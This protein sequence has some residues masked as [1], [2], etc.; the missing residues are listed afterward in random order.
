MCSCLLRYIGL[1]AN[2]NPSV[3]LS[4]GFAPN[5]IPKPPPLDHS[6][7]IFLTIT[8]FSSFHA[9]H[10][11]VASGVAFATETVSPWLRNICGVAIF[12]GDRHGAGFAIKTFASV[13]DGTT[14]LSTL[15]YLF[16][17]F[18]IRF[19]FNSATL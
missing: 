16:R 5:S 2:K 14:H 12:S 17:V 8:L 7:H 11:V 18:W 19:Y 13:Q 9:G 4:S 3:I 1:Q 15:I 10:R 6:I